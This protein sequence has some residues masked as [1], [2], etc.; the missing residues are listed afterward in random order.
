M[1]GRSD[2]GWFRRGQLVAHIPCER[3]SDAGATPPRAPGAG[4]LTRIARGVHRAPSA[5]TGLLGLV[6]GSALVVVTL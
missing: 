5:I 4:H 6:V 3:L 1:P 2:P